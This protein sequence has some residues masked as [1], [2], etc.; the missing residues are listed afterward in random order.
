MLVDVFFR[1]IDIACLLMYFSEALILLCTLYQLF[2][3]KLYMLFILTLMKDNNI[4]TWSLSGLLVTWKHQEPGYQQETCQ[5]QICCFHDPLLLLHSYLE[6]EFRC[7]SAAEKAVE[8]LRE[9]HKDKEILHTYPQDY[10]G[11]TTTHKTG[12]GLY[13]DGLL[14]N[15]GIFHRNVSKWNISTI[16]NAFSH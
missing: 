13:I 9:I 8:R 5:N 1:S 6:L 11:T 7:I 14:Q 16:S 2:S 3:I 15:C 4:S 12:Y 10:K